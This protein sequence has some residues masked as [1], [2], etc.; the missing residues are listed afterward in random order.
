MTEMPEA[1]DNTDEF[2]EGADGAGA[3]AEEGGAGTPVDGV[4]DEDEVAG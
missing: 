3:E 2:Q 4:S 1:V